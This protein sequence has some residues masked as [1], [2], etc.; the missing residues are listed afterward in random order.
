MDETKQTENEATGT[1][2]DGA[3]ATQSASKTGRDYKAWL[4]FIAGIGAVLWG[5]FA[6]LGTSW[7]MWSFKSGLTGLRWSFYMAVAGI[8]LG[9]LFGWLNRRNGVS[10][11]RALHW[12]GMLIALL[13]SGY[14]LNFVV[15]AKSLPAIHDVSTDL[16]DPPAFTQLALRKDNLDNIPGDQDDDMKRMSPEQRWVLLHQKAYGDIRS[17]R[18]EEN[19]AQVIAKAER[20]AKARKWDIAISDPVSGHL[21][22]TETSRFFGFKDDIVLRVKPAQTGSGSIV[23]MRSVS[24]VGQ[25]D[26]GVNAKRIRSFLADLSGTVTTG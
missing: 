26:L 10:G 12:A 16:A 19:V 5:L 14:I 6:G 20:L 25:S 13:Y 8:L 4:V 18:I 24:R 15:T 2:C 11:N 7:D 3:V 1:S 22:A 23:D 21:E 17:V 9:L